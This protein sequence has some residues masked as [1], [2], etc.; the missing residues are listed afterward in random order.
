MNAK[1]LL[2]L[3]LLSLGLNT[4]TDEEYWYEPVKFEFVQHF[5][6]QDSL[7][8]SQH[9]IFTQLKDFSIYSREY[10][11]YICYNYREYSL[12]GEIIDLE[13]VVSIRFERLDGS[14]QA[15]LVLETTYYDARTNSMWGYWYDNSRRL[16]IIDLSNM[17]LVASCV[18]EHSYTMADYY[19]DGDP[20]DTSLTREQY[21][22]LYASQYEEV[23]SCEFKYEY[24]FRSGGLSFKLLKGKPNEFECYT[25]IE[26]GFYLWENYGFLKP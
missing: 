16:H 11:L 7:L 8:K 12:P 2:A 18:L 5:P 21:D 26:E 22:S 24:E 25:N 1:W 13:N 19:Y 10:D 6:S 23:T 14:E 3:A 4:G 15:F 20:Y 17:A 9:G